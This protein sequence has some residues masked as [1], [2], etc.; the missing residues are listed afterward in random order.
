MSTAFL[1]DTLP[2]VDPTIAPDDGMFHR[3]FGED[4][5]RS[6]YAE[7]GRSALRCIRAALVAADRD[8]AT[9]H[10]ILDLP[11]GHGRVLRVLKAAYPRAKITA[12]DLDRSGVDFC[13]R[14]FGAEPAYSV[15]DPAKIPVTG[16]FDLIWCGS[17]LTHFDAPR[18][19][20][21]LGRF[22]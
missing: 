14:Q 7:S 18:W 9:I 3:H 17:L 16:P 11:C 6:H 8:P 19:S 13:A 22:R 1:A 4:V 20:G 15:E 21:L 10:R 2:D 12:C 5:A